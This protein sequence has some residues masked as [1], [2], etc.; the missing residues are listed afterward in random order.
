MHGRGNPGQIYLIPLLLSHQDPCPVVSYTRIIIVT[1][2]ST[3][4]PRAVRIDSH[5]RKPSHPRRQVA[6]CIICSSRIPR[7]RGSPVNSDVQS[8]STESSHATPI[9]ILATRDRRCIPREECSESPPSSCETIPR[10]PSWFRRLT[11][12]AIRV[13]MVR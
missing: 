4:D 11:P 5:K 8:T 9:T 10:S 7:L 2:S 1:E 12:N 6:D 3:E 13:T